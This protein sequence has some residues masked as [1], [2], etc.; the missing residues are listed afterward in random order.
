MFIRCKKFSLMM[1]LLAGSF[2]FS[3]WHHGL[4][5]ELTSEVAGVG[6]FGWKNSKFPHFTGVQLQTLGVRKKTYRSLSSKNALETQQRCQE[7]MEMRNLTVCSGSLRDGFSHL[8]LVTHCCGG[9]ET[10]H[11]GNS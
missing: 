10:G 6:C 5:P 8:M 11:C 2:M 3:Q 1:F 4:N 7:S 9:D